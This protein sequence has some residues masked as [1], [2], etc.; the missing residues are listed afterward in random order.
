[1]RSRTL[2]AAAALFVGSAGIA[3]ALTFQ[4]K[5]KTAPPPQDKAKAAPA[6]AP[7]SAEPDPEMMKKWMAFMTPGADHKVLDSMVGK[8]TTKVRFWMDPAGP[9]QESQGTAEISW[10]MGGRYLQEMDKGEAMGM[11]FEGMGLTAFD[12]LKKKYLGT[13]IDNMGTGIMVSTEGTYDAATKTIT[14]KTEGPDATMSKYVP[15]RIV[16]TITDA[17]THKMEMYGPDK[18]GKEFRSFECT[19]TRAK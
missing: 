14:C 11:P 7:A 15:M 12:N 16:H 19:Y 18:N 8:W 3:A 4:D 2:F 1:M 5:S 17:N 13:W 6:A 10:I 9:V